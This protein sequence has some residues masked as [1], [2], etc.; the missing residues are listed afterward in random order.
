M[1]KRLSPLVFA[2]FFLFACKP[3]TLTPT[4]SPL[5]PTATKTLRPTATPAPVETL[6]VKE[7]DLNGIEI[8]VW[9]TWFGAPA[10]LFESQIEEFNKENS[11]GIIVSESYRGS[12]N[13]LFNDVMD[14]K[15]DRPPVI[16]A[17]PEQL[18]VWSE[19]GTVQDLMPY[20][21]DPNWGF[22]TAEKTD[23]P[24]VF[25]EQD[26][27]E[28]QILALPAQ[29]TARF[30]L[31]NQTWGEELGFKSAPLSFDEFKE[32]SCAA[33]LSKRQDENPEDDGKGGWIID[34]DTNGILAWMRGFGG[35]PFINDEY[36]FI[37][38]NNIS[39]FKN[40]K[41]LYD[42]KC[43][44]LTTAETP[45]EQF[46]LRSA[47]FITASL[48][49]FPQIKRA[50]LDAGSR[51][52]WTVIPFPGEERNVLITYGSSY[53]LMETED[54]EAL[55][56]WLFVKWML[57][58]ENQA[59]WTKST[60]LFPLRISAINELSDYEKANPQW[61]EAVNL[62]TQAE[63][64]PQLASWHKIRY[65]LGDGF[66]FLFRSDLQAGSVAAILAQMNDAA[67]ALSE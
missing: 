52:E 62:I 13:M 45:Y 12:Y 42:D 51:D 37:N 17:L 21:T 41:K 48:E 60:A 29:R 14:E 9:H 7:E 53:A 28:E 1:V 56:A 44:W 25:L 33:N 27:R 59:K 39:A 40:L 63:I 20:I 38:S 34:Y 49:E 18:S 24:S 57:T 67:R 47:L 6:E 16:V 3:E 55:A 5:P 36:Q 11:W 66:E 22:T 19:L 64:Y 61:A 23:F 26:Q 58:P 31:Y 2:F 10:A 43:A 35:G 46:A 54:A 65:L 4:P 30:I 50:F 15:A 8:E 32:Q